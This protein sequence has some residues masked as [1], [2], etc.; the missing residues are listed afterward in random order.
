LI[1]INY[2]SVRFHCWTYAP[3][4]RYR[5][6]Y[7]GT[8]SKIKKSTGAFMELSLSRCVWRAAAGR[9][10]SPL[11]AA[12]GVL[13]LTG[14]GPDGQPGIT[15]AQ[16][17]GTT[18]AF[19]SV[20]GPPSAQFHKLVQDLND[21]AQARQLA[22]VARDK[23]SVYRV[24]GYL[25]AKI[26][27]SHT[28]VSWVWDVFDQNEHRALR[29]SGAETVKGRRGWAAADDKMLERIAHGSME[30]LTVFL[31]SPEVAPGAPAAAAPEPK[32]VAFMG[33]HNVSPEAAGIFRIFRAQVTDD[34]PADSAAATPVNSPQPIPQPRSR[35]ASPAAVSAHE[36]TTLS[37][38]R[39]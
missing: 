6:R 29:I 1:E 39:G 10:V 26:V 38:S 4:S 35:P 8:N 13:L 37:A 5:A 18:V 12:V 31:A 27:K 25:A 11:C 34:S 9:V 20:D 36:T 16:P 17:R 32:P 24:R 2:H 3:Q 22:V 21:E 28:E 15:A 33:W 19:E 14:C 7:Q 30:Q 23:P